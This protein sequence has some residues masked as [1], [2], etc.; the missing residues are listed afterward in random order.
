MGKTAAVTAVCNKGRLKG[1]SDNLRGGGSGR[2]TMYAS[3]VMDG[4]NEAEGQVP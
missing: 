2:R 4:D 3:M 1:E